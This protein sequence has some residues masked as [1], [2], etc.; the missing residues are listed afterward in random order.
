M[1]QMPGNYKAI[2][3]I[4]VAAALIKGANNGKTGVEILPSKMMQNGSAK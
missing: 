3:P 1:G 4:D 2:K